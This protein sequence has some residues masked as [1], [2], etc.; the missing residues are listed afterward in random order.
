MGDVTDTEGASSP[1]L[2]GSSREAFSDYQVAL[3]PVTGPSGGRTWWAHFKFTCINI[4]LTILHKEIGD[5]REATAC[6]CSLA[7]T[8]GKSSVVAAPRRSAGSP[9]VLNY[10][11]DFLYRF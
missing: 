11:S 4:E 5:C 10:R 3:S 8:K 7:A 2:V 1:S 9:N 6:C